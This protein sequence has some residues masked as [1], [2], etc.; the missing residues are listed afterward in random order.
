MVVSL[1][2]GCFRSSNDVT[3]KIKKTL[4]E[5]HKK[6]Q[7]IS[8]NGFCETN[9]DRSSRKYNLTL[10]KTVYSVS[11]QK[12]GFSRPKMCRPVSHAYEMKFFFLLE[13]FSKTSD[14][15]PVSFIR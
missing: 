8:N 2:C 1:C 6:N 5:T 15:H 3:Q 11:A 14:E 13:V 9:K 7:Y 12:L 10:G 4:N